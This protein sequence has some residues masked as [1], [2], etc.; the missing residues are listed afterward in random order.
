M[1]TYKDKQARRLA[2]IAGSG[3]VAYDRDSDRFVFTLN[4]E[5][6]IFLADFARAI[7]AITAITNN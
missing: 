5:T 2:Q 4:G 1:N 7:S 6:H 3:T